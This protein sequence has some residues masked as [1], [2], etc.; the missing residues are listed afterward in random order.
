MHKRT[1]ALAAI[2]LSAGA[3]AQVPEALYSGMRYRPVGPFRGG[4]ALAVS[5][6]R[7]QPLTWYFGAVAGGVFR[8]DNAGQS[9]T[10]I[11]DKQDN[12]SIGALAVAE[13][14]PNILYVGT[15][16]AC[17]RGNVTYGK[18]VYRSDDAGRTWRHLGLSDTRQIGK[19]LVHPRN[20]DLVYVAALGHAFGPNAERGVFRSRDGGGSWDKIL[21]K[22]ADT[23]AIDLAFDP[24]NPQVLFAALW[25]VRR[26]P[27]SLE[28]GGPGSGLYRSHDGGT[29]WTHLAGHGLPEGDL[30]RI[31]VAVSPV[32]GRRVYASVEA[33]A[34][35]L[36]VSDDGGDTWT[37]ASDD[38]RIRQ[39]AWYFSHIWADPKARETIYL[40]NTG[41][42]RSTDGGKSLQL[43]PAK[44]G[45]HHGLWVD[46]DDSRRMI[47]S[48]D[49][50]ASISLDGGQTWS[51]TDN[52]QPTAQFYHVAADNHFPYRL[53]GA[54]QDNT[55][56]AVQSRSDSGVIGDQQWYPLGIGEAAYIA[57]DP[58]DPDVAFASTS[59]GAM[60]RYDHRTEQTQALGPWPFETAGRG[61]GELAHRF[62]WLTPLF[63]SPHD[64]DVIYAGSEVV[65]KSA[66]QGHTWKAISKDLTR[67]D[68][69]KQKPSGGALT[70]D[71]TSV[72]YFD[73]VFA[74]AESPLEKG[75]IWAG[76]DDG[77][78]HVSRDGGG[79]W[80]N[81]TPKDLP[82][83]GTVS[84]IEASPHAA[85]TATIAVDRHRLDDLKPYLFRTENF[86]KSWKRIVAGI[87]EGAFTRAVREDPRQKGLLYAGT[88]AG[89]YVSFDA[90]ARWQALK[91]N[92]P[93][94]PVHDV[95]IKGDD[96]LVATHGR[97][98]WI[99]DNV[100][101][102]R[103]IAAGAGVGELKLYEPQVALRLLWPESFD[104]RLPV[105]ENPPA[106]AVIDYYFKSKPVGEVVIKIA[107]A[108]GKIVRTLSSK[109][110]RT[111]GEQPQEWPDLQKPAELLPVEAG[112]NRFPWDLRFDPPAEL[113]GA[114]YPSLPPRGPM[115][116]PGTYTLRLEADGKAAT[117]TMVV[118]PD[119]R[120]KVTPGALAELV[121]LQLAV[122]DRM[123]ALH[124][125]VL[126][127]R[128]AREQLAA[129]TRRASKD[130][131]FAPLV[132]RAES[133]TTALTEV[134]RRLVAVDV[135][136]TEGTLRFP[137]QL[138]EKFESLRGNLEGAEAAPVPALREAFA[139]YDEELQA[140]LKRLQQL[141][142]ELD[143]FNAEAR[144]LELP[145]VSL[146]PEEARR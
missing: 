11:F 130:Q 143:A 57:P 1:L 100:T 65:W 26:S 99:L 13:S 77:L 129:L 10:P 66:D 84:V 50:G 36:F 21:F 123:S 73:T 54:Q 145:A 14:D 120:I 113:P 20:A 4:R 41:L 115:V 107:A 69:E 2:L 19:V 52:N 98:F 104:R 140:Q 62:Q 47:E 137:V 60:N 78:V 74:L 49:G 61:A 71:I 42:Y 55:S 25:Q 125:A 135:K 105:G 144:K 86:G 7:G 9:W 93:S 112:M 22:N 141:R 35:G 88:E 85:G 59:G 48:S 6:V 83:W 32:D 92:L 87:P 39:R 43:L 28:S 109:L 15:G 91:L 45:D 37:R 23:G 90:G 94:V 63:L 30:G 126:S 146:Q 27:W 75:V 110:H 17:I 79:A 76:T 3:S 58:R 5:G 114:F 89:V 16:E 67:D 117:A 142:A 119:P 31:G 96:L 81:V 133:T 33:K 56:I 29:T 68:K 127:L 53:Y 80:K 82:E 124:E 134:E 106:G 8:T 72:E 118:A 95:I 121:Q 44:H 116:I 103:Q 12:L 64:P 70:L 131:R 111:E 139:S 132:T 102:L 108:D 24:Q 40:A 101:P 51:R 38:E 128:S 46:P 97:A 122:R 18:G 138:N 136:S 34:G